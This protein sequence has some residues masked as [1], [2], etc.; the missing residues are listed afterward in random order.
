MNTEFERRFA[1]SR[2]W[3]AL[4]IAA[5][6][7]GALAAW[8]ALSNPWSWAPAT[9]FFLTGLF[10]LAI[11]FSPVI[12]VSYSHL[13]LGKRRVEW[14]QLESVEH[15]GW[16]SPLVLKLRLRSEPSVLLVCAATMEESTELL[17]LL[18]EQMMPE[19]EPE[20]I[21]EPEKILTEAEMALL[22]RE[23]VRYPLML[24]EDEAEIQRL[25]QRLKS[26]GRLDNGRDE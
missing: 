20:A 15:T 14:D 17:N 10:L 11:S 7:C 3:L 18:E 26:V 19:L 23:R 12:V 21:E 5:F 2:T 4:S 24:P 9:L 6:A 1:P 13:L 22:E 16:V 25:Y 8:L